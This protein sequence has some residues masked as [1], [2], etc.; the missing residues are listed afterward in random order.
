MSYDQRFVVHQNHLFHMSSTSY[1]TPPIPTINLHDLHGCTIKFNDALTTIPTH[2]AIV[3][4]TRATYTEAEL[5]LFSQ[6][7]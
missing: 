2:P 4:D 3:Q 6:A 1:A 7:D 5:K